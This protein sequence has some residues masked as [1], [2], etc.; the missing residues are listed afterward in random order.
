M[1]PQI[2]YEEGELWSPNLKAWS[3]PRGFKL[4][5]DFLSIFMPDRFYNAQGPNILQFPLIEWAIE[6]MGCNY[7]FLNIIIHFKAKE[8]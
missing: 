7:G 5:A 1:S 3:E 8:Q 4:S 6:D 2:L